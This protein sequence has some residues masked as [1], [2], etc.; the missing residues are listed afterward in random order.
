MNEHPRPW[1]AHLKCG[2]ATP[3]SVAA[4]VGNWV[5]CGICHDQRAITSVSRALAV[6]P[7]GVQGELWSRAE[8]EQI[9]ATREAA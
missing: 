3:T 9:A 5:S 2:H 6:V 7:A 8:V 4:K 1:L